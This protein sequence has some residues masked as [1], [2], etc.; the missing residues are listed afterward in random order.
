M[1]LPPE[2][3]PLAYA[4]WRRLADAEGQAIRAGN[5]ALVAECQNAVATL[6]S[7]IDRL[8]PS[9]AAPRGKPSVTSRQ[10]ASD[11]RGSILELIELQRKNL[12]SLEE[13]RRRLSEHVENLT[14][15]GRKLRSIQRSYSTPAT[16]GFSSYS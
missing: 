7:Q 2:D 3:L 10:R 1:S 9:V 14:S 5:W 13:R 12:A 16:G 8:S 4:E 6:R 11:L 15:A